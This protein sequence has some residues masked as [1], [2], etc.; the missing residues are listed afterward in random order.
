[1]VIVLIIISIFYCQSIFGQDKVKISIL[2]EGAL[3][4]RPSLSQGS[5]SFSVSPK[6]GGSGQQLEYSPNLKYYKNI[7]LSLYGMSLSYGIKEDPA[8]KD[9]FL[10]GK[11][12]FS[13]FQFHFANGYF[14][15]DLYYQKFTGMFLTSKEFT[16]VSSFEG[17]SVNVFEQFPNM[18]QRM[19]GVNLMFIFSPDKFKYNSVFNQSERQQASG[20]SFI[21]SLSYLYSQI[22]NDSA[23]LPSSE[24]TKYESDGAIRSAVLKTIGPLFGHAYN[25]TN[26]NWFWAYMLS[27]GIGVQKRNIVDTSVPNNDTGLTGRLNG[28]LSFG[29]NGAILFWG[30]SGL[31][32]SVNALTDQ[33]DLAMSS[34]FVEIFIGFRM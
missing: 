31:V 22:Y 28:R 26:G 30:V 15:L 2:G 27:I 23:F 16:E 33:I 29:Y 10:K 25:F 14:G 6:E 19:R 18:F 13:D 20:G 24:Q 1:M 8:P 12:D 3:M 17:T 11:T 21:F 9:Q 4:F 32:D 7:Q 5:A 34:N